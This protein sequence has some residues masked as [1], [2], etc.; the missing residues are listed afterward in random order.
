MQDQ[1]TKKCSAGHGLIYY[2]N[3]ESNYLTNKN[4]RSNAF[5]MYVQGIPA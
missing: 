1:Q 4:S 5:T 3:K 2:E